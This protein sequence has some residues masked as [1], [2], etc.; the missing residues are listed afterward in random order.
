MSAMRTRV[1]DRV[2]LCFHGGIWKEAPGRLSRNIF[3][4][5]R[6][7]SRAMI[8][9]M[10]AVSAEDGVAPINVDSWVRVHA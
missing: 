2:R 6:I 7:R 1:G 8:Q 3:R 9:V 5:I 4:V 10:P